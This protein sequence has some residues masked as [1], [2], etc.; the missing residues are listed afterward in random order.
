MKI[1][2]EKIDE[3]I[4]HMP[5]A[6]KR[7]VISEFFRDKNHDIDNFM[8]ET[9]EDLSYLVNFRENEDEIRELFS[10]QLL[11][12]LDKIFREYASNR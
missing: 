8:Y 10:K 11:Y 12:S 4:K 6:D 3:G 9:F 2:K 5:G 7:M 1:V